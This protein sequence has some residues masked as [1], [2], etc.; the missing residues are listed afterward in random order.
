MVEYPYH[1][2]HVHPIL[3]LTLAF[4]NGLIYS[5]PLRFDA[6]WCGDG[7]VGPS[8]TRD[9]DKN[10]VVASVSIGS[11]SFRL[12][13][14]QAQH[15]YQHHVGG[16][17]LKREEDEDVEV[18]EVKEGGT[19]EDDDEEPQ[20]ISVPVHGLG[21]VNVRSTPTSRRER[22][23]NRWGFFWVDSERLVEELSKE[24]GNVNGWMDLSC[25]YRVWL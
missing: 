24:E 16:S 2:R 18:K 3:L 1:C 23:G 21:T 9:R 25:Y 17:G 6:F 22:G 14:H 5:S 7:V 8:E 15:Q 12:L 11:I 20:S 13:E 4:L 19:V 10:F